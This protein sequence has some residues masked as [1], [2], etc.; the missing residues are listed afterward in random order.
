[1]WRKLIGLAFWIAPRGTTRDDL[2]ANLNGVENAE[3]LKNE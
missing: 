2:I 1:V 3:T